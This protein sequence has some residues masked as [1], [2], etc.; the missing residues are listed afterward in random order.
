MLGRN[1]GRLVD[2]TDLKNTGTQGRR[3]QDMQNVYPTA[4][5]LGDLVVLALIR[6]AHRTES[7]TLLTPENVSK[8]KP[9]AQVLGQRKAYLRR[10]DSW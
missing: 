4:D 9:L 8:L 1:V 5:E 2:C 10:E 3:R 6:R 7:S